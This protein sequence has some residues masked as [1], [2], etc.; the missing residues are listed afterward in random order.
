MFAATTRHS[1]LCLS[2]FTYQTRERYSKRSRKQSN[3]DLEHSISFINLFNSAK[4]L[5]LK[6]KITTRDS[7]WVSR[8]MT[9]H[10]FNGV[11]QRLTKTLSSRSI[12]PR[13]ITTTTSKVKHQTKPQKDSMT[14]RVTSKFKNKTRSRE[15]TPAVTTLAQ[16][17]AIKTSCK[18]RNNRTTPM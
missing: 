3:T 17:T 15:V 11:R 9:R 6:T 13:V 4:W 5:T 7:T 12:Q 1:H 8:L 2:P 10:S 16:T 14:F 18:N